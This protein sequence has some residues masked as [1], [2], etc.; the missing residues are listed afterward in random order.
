MN[1]IGKLL[2]I[3]VIGLN[4]TLSVYAAPAESLR[5]EDFRKTERRAR[6]G[7]V[8][9]MLW[10]AHYYTTYVPDDTLQA[11]WYGQAARRGD[12]LAEKNL[13]NCYLEGIGVEK[14]YRKALEWYDRAARKGYANALHNL[15]MMYA[16]G[17]GV[18]PSD[19]IA[20]LYFRQAAEKGFYLSEYM[21]GWCYETGCC[22]ETDYRSA[23]EIGRAHV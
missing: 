18:S 22:V 15:G 9:A 19:S 13:G 12:T 4:A 7:N 21:I 17:W 10:L 6:K 23:Y 5:E 1:G 3:T 11:Y 20:Y 14:D 16:R 2:W 8:P